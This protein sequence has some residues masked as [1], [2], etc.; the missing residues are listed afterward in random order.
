MQA[1]L[2]MVFT[3]QLA[4]FRILSVYLEAN[5]ETLIHISALKFDSTVVE[6]CTCGT[7]GLFWLRLWRRDGKEEEEGQSIMAPHSI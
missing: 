5:I 2:G 1:E 3:Q 4:F 6:S 7:P